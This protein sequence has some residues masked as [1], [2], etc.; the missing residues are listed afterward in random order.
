[1][2]GQR[3]ARKR[4]PADMQTE[5]G[6][7]SWTFEFINFAPYHFILQNYFYKKKKM[8]STY[9]ETKIKFVL[10]VNDVAPRP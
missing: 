1:M 10:F 6:E 5:K 7:K 4:E 3:E 9:N 8:P 2:D